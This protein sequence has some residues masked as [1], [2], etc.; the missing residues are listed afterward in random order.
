MQQKTCRST[1]SR[2]FLPPRNDATSG[3]SLPGTSKRQDPTQ[4]AEL[5][6]RDTKATAHAEMSACPKRVRRFRRSDIKV[7]GD[8]RGHN[9][10]GINLLFFEE[11]GADFRPTTVVLF[12]SCCLVQRFCRVAEFRNNGLLAGNEERRLCHETPMHTQAF[13]SSRIELVASRVN[14]LDRRL[15]L[16]LVNGIID[17]EIFLGSHRVLPCSGSRYGGLVSQQK[18]C[19]PSLR[20]PGVR[21]CQQL[22]CLFMV[23]WTR[24]RVM[25][26]WSRDSECKGMNL[27]D[28]G[29]VCHICVEASRIP[30]NSLISS[31][32]CPI[33]QRGD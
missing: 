24:L 21:L 15:P 27:L 29:G 14:C 12:I 19:F 20:S 11:E 23:N 2:P 3:R 6:G 16:H 5:P 9:D 7:A 22:Q 13:A 1:G 31:P 10:R 25:A 4:H 8:R 26:V 17:A 33:G 32:P 28:C 30:P 18:D